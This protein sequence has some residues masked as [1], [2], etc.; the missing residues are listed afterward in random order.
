MVKQMGETVA[1]GL[2][3]CYLT[4]VEA[5]KRTSVEVQAEGAGTLPPALACA[6]RRTFRFKKLVLAVVRTP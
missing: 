1:R 4:L 6:G 3:L 2:I 5:E